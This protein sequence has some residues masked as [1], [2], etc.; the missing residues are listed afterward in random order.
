MPTFIPGQLQQGSEIIALT[1]LSPPPRRG[2]KQMLESDYEYPKNPILLP[3]EEQLAI[4]EKSHLLASPPLSPSSQNSRLL[5]EVSG[6]V[7]AAREWMLAEDSSDTETKVT[8]FLDSDVSSRNSI[9]S[10]ELM[11]I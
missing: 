7:S 9:I 2:P 8:S 5:P 4:D 11:S 10:E 3:F 1:S 6:K